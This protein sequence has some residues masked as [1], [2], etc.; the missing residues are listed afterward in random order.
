MVAN[1]NDGSAAA[2]GDLKQRCK[3]QK[4]IKWE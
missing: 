4:Y 1:N 2:D 3:V